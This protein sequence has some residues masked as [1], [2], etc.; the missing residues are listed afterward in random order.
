MNLTVNGKA[1]AL[2]ADALSVT[3]LLEELQVA[4]REYVTVELNGDILDRAEC[5]AHGSARGGETRIDGTRRGGREHRGVRRAA[6]S[7][8]YPRA[9]NQTAE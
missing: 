8:T 7:I 6:R 2:A 3:K 1:A 5:V 4:Q 9:L